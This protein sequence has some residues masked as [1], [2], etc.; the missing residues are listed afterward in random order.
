MALDFE[1]LTV[2]PPAADIVM[3]D[4]VRVTDKATPLLLV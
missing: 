4:C 3:A 2:L 1:K